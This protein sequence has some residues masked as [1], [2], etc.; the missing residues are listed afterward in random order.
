MTRQYLRKCTLIVSTIG[1]DGLDLSALHITFRISQADVQAPNTAQIRVWNLSPAT[2]KRIEKEFTQVTLQAGYGD[3]VNV[4]FDG[5]IVQLRRGRANATDT[6]LE[7]SASDGDAAYN[8][9]II[10]TSLAA[11]AKPED[12]Y[13]AITAAFAKYGASAADVPA[14][15]FNDQTTPRGK[16][17]FGMARDYMRDLADTSLSTWSIQN[18]K[19]IVVKTNSYL[20]G[21]AVVVNSQSGMIGIPEQTV[22]GVNVRVL[23]NPRLKYCGRIQ[24]NEGDINRAAVSL[25]AASPTTYLPR[26]VEDGFYRIVVCNHIGDTRGE[27]WYSDLICVA[28]DDTTPPALIDRGYA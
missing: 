10:A 13:A 1:G 17:M 2:S 4:I 6:Y 26:L 12:Q 28:L 9:G 16:V 15:T 19:V 5:T 22:G 21:E 23:L 24:V 20:P 8:F 7:I 27:D 25:N 11:G 14:G 18:G 3:D